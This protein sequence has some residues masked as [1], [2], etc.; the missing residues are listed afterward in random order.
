MATTPATI[1]V[2]SYGVDNLLTG[3]IVLNE[4]ITE[5]DIVHQISDQKGAISAEYPYDKRYDLTL[6]VQG[7]GSLPACGAVAFSY[8][9]AVWKVE[10]ISKPAVYNDTV[11]YTIT[12]YR[13]TNFPSQT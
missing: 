10:K 1:P 5:T 11:K 4:E 12:A 7:S 3:F 8:A 2:V 9:S 13:Y 6:T